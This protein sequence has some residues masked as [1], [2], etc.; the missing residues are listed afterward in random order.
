MLHRLAACVRALRSGFLRDRRAA[1]SPLMAIMIIPIAGA[2]AMVT[3]LGQW[4]YFQRSLQNAADSAAIAAATN[5]SATGS[6]YLF[7]ARAAAQKFGFV[8]GQD[9][10]SV[11]ASIVTC[12]AGSPVGAVCYQASLSKVLPIAISAIVGFR[13][14]ANGG[15]AQTIPAVAVATTSGSAKTACIWSLSTGTNSFNSNGGP[16][17][18]LAGCNIL[19]NGDATCNGHDLGADVGMAAGVSSGCGK[20][21]VSGAT[22]PTDPYAAKATRIPT[23]PCTGAKPYPEKPVGSLPASNKLSGTM[24]LGTSATRCGDVVLTGDVT[25]TGSNV[26]TIYNGTLDLNG[27]TLKTETGSSANATLI[28]SGTNAESSTSTKNPD[29]PARAPTGSGTL[30]I[31]APTSGDWSGVALY[32]D[33]RM[34]PPQKNLDVKYTGNQPTWNITGLVYLPRSNT[35]FSGIVNKSGDG[36]SCFVLVAY[37]I[38][39]NG[40]G[41]IFANNN[42]CGTAGLPAPSIGAATREKLVL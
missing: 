10:T 21:Q 41:S 2:T 39:V 30:D 8:D 24:N 26:L 12:P 11:T 17:P 35:T 37:T 14:D 36:A 25:L 13:G 31:K 42:Q 3:E 4:Y 28:F 20:A 6:T 32:Q 1:I 33:P 5:N 15:F 23:N 38:L 18:D 22:P 27:H 7:E 9:N 34:T 19:S 16:K 40:T 29:S